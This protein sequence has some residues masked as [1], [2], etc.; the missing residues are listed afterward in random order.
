MTELARLY[1]RFPVIEPNFRDEVLI[2]EGKSR[3][4]ELIRLY[5]GNDWVALTDY[6]QHRFIGEGSRRELVF[7]IP[8]KKRNK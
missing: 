4:P 1:F 3:L 5:T 8:A 6:T 7:V 2:S